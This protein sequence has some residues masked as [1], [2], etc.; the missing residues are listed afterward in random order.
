MPKNN[1]KLLNRFEMEQFIKRYSFEP[2]GS[3]VVVRV[4]GFNRPTLQS[5]FEK[6]SLYCKGRYLNITPQAIE[7]WE[8][9]F[10][11]RNLIEVQQAI[12]TLVLMYQQI[13]VK[14]VE[15]ILNNEI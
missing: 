7:I 13:D 14:D 15:K 9:N 12:N 6:F 2:S 8:K 1:I 10:Q 3:F 4:N 11:N 5:K